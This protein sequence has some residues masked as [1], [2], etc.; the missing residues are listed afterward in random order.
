MHSCSMTKLMSKLASKIFHIST[1]LKILEEYQGVK[2]FHML[3]CIGFYCNIMVLKLR[4][5]IIT[6]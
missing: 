4:S 2:E 1:S 3:A 6:H 5:H